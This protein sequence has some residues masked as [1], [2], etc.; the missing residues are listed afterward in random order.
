LLGLHN[1]S[2]S[3][4]WDYGSFMRL[5]QL[6]DG[7]LTMAKEEKTND[8]TPVRAELAMDA[9]PGAP[10]A[11]GAPASAMEPASPPADSLTA[12]QVAELKAKAAKADEHWSR[13]LRQTAD[14]DNYK[15]RVARERQEDLKYAG[16]SVLEKLIPVIDN[17][18][19]GLASASTSTDPAV[20]S[21]HTGITM[22]FNQLK[23]ALFE[24]GLEEIDAAGQNFDPNLHEAVSH[25][26]SDQVADGQVLRQLRKGYRLKDRLLRPATV[27]V[28]RKPTA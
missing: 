9:A 16:R 4:Y 8:E 27:V 1:V 15:K 24:A 10:N 3:F 18:E 19:M 28:A 11:S 22:V 23:A 5:R 2:L 21:M 20:R 25:E 13:L 14:F 26:E 12:D 6:S 17:F 7:V